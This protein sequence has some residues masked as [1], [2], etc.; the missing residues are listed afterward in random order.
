MD[1]VARNLADYGWE[2]EATDDELIARE[3][4]TRLCCVESPAKVSL[5]FLPGQGGTDV[6][7]EASVSGFGPISS[8]NA[9]NRLESVAR[10]VLRAGSPAPPSA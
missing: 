1:R 5:K 4:A 9:R 7:I 2:I 10:V 6:L 3:D 8:R